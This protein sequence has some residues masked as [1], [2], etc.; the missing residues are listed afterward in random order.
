MVM[1]GE[2]TSK[3]LIRLGQNL[4]LGRPKGKAFALRRSGPKRAPRQ[5]FRLEGS[6]PEEP[7][8]LFEQGGLAA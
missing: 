2:I 7:S 4:V 8:V 1:S 5:Y 3:G 6:I